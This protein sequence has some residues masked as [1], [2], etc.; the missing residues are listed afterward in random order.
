MQT[1]DDLLVRMTLEEKVGQ[2]MMVGFD[3]VVLEPGLRAMLAEFHLGGIVEFLRN[4]ESPRQLAQLNADLQKAARASGHP[5]LF[6][7]IDQ[8]GGRVARLKAAQG[9]TEFP[10]A[11]QVGASPEPAEAARRVAHGMAAEMKAAGVNMD[12]APVLDVN[13]NPAN[14]IIGT[15][16]YSADPA[17]VAACGVAFLETLQAEGIAAVGKHFPGHGDTKVDSHVALAVVPHDLARLQSVEF[18][19]FRAAIQAGVTGIMSAHSAFPSID[20]TPN[21]AATLSSK[22]MTDL[23]RDELGFG[24]IRMTDSLEMGALA[25]SGYP[26]PLAAAAA[27]KAGA[28]VLLFNRDHALHRAAH[29]MVVDWLKRGEIPL[30]RLDEAVRRVLAAKARFRIF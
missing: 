19:P 26:V 2:V 8:E 30:A 17:C 13:N 25:T 14:P 18:V 15:R 1:T 3:G 21:L 23:L 16:S 24:G 28:D 7:S 11:D 27:L 20:P 22:V 4:V 12:L 10:A 5:G 29:A 6:I 9:F